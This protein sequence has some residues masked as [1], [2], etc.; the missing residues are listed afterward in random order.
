[1]T[2]F[3]VIQGKGRTTGFHL[4]FVRNAS[5]V[6]KYSI[7][8]LRLCCEYSPCHQVCTRSACI[9]GVSANIKQAVHTSAMTASCA[10]V[11]FLF[12]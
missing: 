6:I 7:T 9:P 3:P 10:L 1:M 4:C 11:V 8:K 5:Q 12:D 2:A